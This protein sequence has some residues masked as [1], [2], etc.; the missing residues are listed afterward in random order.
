M[1]FSDEQLIYVL[2][3]CRLQQM[4]LPF[5][6]ITSDTVR[7]ARVKHHIDVERRRLLPIPFEVW[8]AQVGFPIPQPEHRR[9]RLIDDLV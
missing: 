2:E 6:E 5:A 4:T 9:L 3:R 7:M 8:A 1:Y